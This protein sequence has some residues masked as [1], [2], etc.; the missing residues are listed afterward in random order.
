[1]LIIH[2]DMCIVL[3]SSTNQ[4]CILHTVHTYVQF[5]SRHKHSECIPK[6]PVYLYH[7]ARHLVQAI[8]IPTGTTFRTEGRRW[9]R[10]LGDLARYIHRCVPAMEGIPQRCFDF[11]WLCNISGWWFYIFLIDETLG[12][13]LMTF[14]EI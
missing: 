7:L 2:G 11:C 12:V 13:D 4:E 9:R 5:Q 14:N 8:G 1:M 3:T 6:C 10:T